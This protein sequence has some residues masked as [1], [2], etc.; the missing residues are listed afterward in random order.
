MGIFKKGTCV[1]IILH[2]HIPASAGKLCGCDAGSLS[3]SLSF[4]LRVKF[5]AI[6]N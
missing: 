5:N 6:E 3:L 4:S 2:G 1:H